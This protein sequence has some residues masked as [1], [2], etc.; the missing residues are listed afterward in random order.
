MPDRRQHR[1]PHPDDARLFARD[2]WP[3]LRRASED[4]RWLLSR[5]YA[6]PSA[7]K[8]V[9]DRYNL[10]ARQRTA[11]SRCTCGAS[12][13][14]RRAEHRTA[15]EALAGAALWIDGYNVLTTVEAALAGGVVLAADDGTY[16]DMASVHGTFRRVAETAPALERIGSTLDALGVGPC[17]WLLDRPVSNSGR[18][19]RLIEDLAADRDWPWRVEL[20]DDPDPI[21]VRCDERIATADSAVLDEC[22][23]WV[24]LARATVERHAAE[25]W[26]VPIG[27]ASIVPGDR[28]G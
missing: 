5:A 3:H 15:L 7:L 11:V 2:A 13:A 25:A 26:V 10:V 12:H 27:R 21:L 1:G 22:R 9:G 16:R 18:L 4:L 20:V 14:R 6:R 24:N 8:L 17:R 23:A 28:Q 19:K